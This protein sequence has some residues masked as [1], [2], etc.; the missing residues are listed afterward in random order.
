MASY[1][2]SLYSDPDKYFEAFKVYQHRSIAMF[3][4]QWKTEWE[5]IIKGLSDRGVVQPDHDVRVLA[6]ATGQGC[7][8]QKIIETLV[9][10]VTASSFHV[11]IIEPVRE[12]LEK[13]KADARNM[14]AKFPSLS[15]E[16]FENTFEGYMAKRDKDGHDHKFHLLV[17]VHGLY[18]MD[19][20]TCTVDRFY[21]LLLPGGAMTNAISSGESGC[22]KLIVKYR[23]WEGNRA[24]LLTS[25]DIASYMKTKELNYH[26]Y[27]REDAID[28]SEVFDETSAEG[29]MVLDF[30]VQRKHFRKYSPEDLLTKVLDF[31]K[32]NSREENGKHYM[33]DAE[34]EIVVIKSK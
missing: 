32:E 22:G 5:T 20:W 34:V 6:V 2:Q 1:L 27:V 3:D 12:Q 31:V 33:S 18:H 21:D 10:V 16:W 15:F 11:E 26:V 25:H 19:D 4:Q 24:D 14:T 30:L 23:D 28:V 13:F 17:C 7:R 29:N 8:E 9:K